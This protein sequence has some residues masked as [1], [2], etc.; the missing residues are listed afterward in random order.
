MKTT[1]MKTTL[2]VALIACFSLALMGCSSQEQKDISAIRNAVAKMDKAP[3]PR[4]PDHSESNTIHTSKGALT[5]STCEGKK[6][7]SGR[8]YTEGPSRATGFFLSPRMQWANDA[9]EAE[10][11]LIEDYEAGNCETSL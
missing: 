4:K 8:I 6:D 10:R 3:M 11:L 5:I 1:Q 9:K 2:Y 7:Q